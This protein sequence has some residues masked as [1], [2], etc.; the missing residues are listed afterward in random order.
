MMFSAILILTA[1]LSLPLSLAAND[2]PAP[3]PNALAPAEPVPGSVPL[4]DENYRLNPGDKLLFSVQEDPN[5]GSQ[6]DELMVNAH[7]VVQFAVSRHGQE[8]VQLSVK[9]KT[10]KQVRDELKIKLDETYYNNCTIDLLLREASPRIGQVFL[11]GKG[12]RGNFIFLKPDRPT[13][14]L[15]GVHEAGVNEFANLKKVKLGRRNATTGKLEF[16]TYNLED[17]KKGKAEDVELQDGD[18][19]EVDERSFVI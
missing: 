6:P 3:A 13:T 14:L 18:Q 8:R 16:K 11:T 19:I 5:R 10:L 7:G 17:I 12:V 9:G 15:R 2:G 1:A 4:A